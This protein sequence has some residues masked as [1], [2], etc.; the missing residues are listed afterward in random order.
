M[1]ENALK[2]LALA[3]QQDPDEIKGML[4]RNG[5]FTP[6]TA[7]LPT[8]NKMTLAALGSSEAFRNDMRDW[9]QSKAGSYSNVVGGDPV[10]DSTTT[11]GTTDGKPNYSDLFKFLGDTT[12]AIINY[13]TAR[14]QNQ[15]LLA[16]NE[17]QGGSSG[18]N[19]G[20]SAT[21][22]QGNSG[23]S[24]TKILLVVG[25]VAVVGGTIY[26]FTRK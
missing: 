3:I 6:D 1:S 25:L 14:E 21:T 7:D 18:E 17:A 19:D 22:D 10:L 20:V 24:T 23:F 11:G 2:N 9:A 5:V 8:L 12:V 16:M 15:A 4:K 13:R 26:F